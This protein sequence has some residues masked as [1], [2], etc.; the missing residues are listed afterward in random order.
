MY[1]YKAKLKRVVDGDTL[2]LIIDLGFRMT[3]QQR[4]RLKGIDTPEIWRRKKDSEEYRKGME[5]KEFVIKRFEVNQNQCSINTEKEAG[6]Y[7][8]FIGTIFFSD[9]TESLNEELLRK[10]YAQPYN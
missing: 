2:D 9:S 4:I 7:G 6:V 1:E 5:A 10:G 8:R 3:T